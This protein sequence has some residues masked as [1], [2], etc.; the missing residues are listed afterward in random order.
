VTAR[1][2]REGAGHLHDRVF[3]PHTFRFLIRD[4]DAKFTS[5]FDTIL[6]SRGPCRVEL[7]ERDGRE[8]GQ[9]P[10]SEREPAASRGALPN[11]DLQDAVVGLCR[12]DG[13]HGDSG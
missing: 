1:L 4:R 13:R 10:R 9:H 11:G 3:E 2:L 6:E 5:V 12:A 8:R 7:T